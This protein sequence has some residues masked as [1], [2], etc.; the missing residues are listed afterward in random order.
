MSTL[1]EAYGRLFHGVTPS[2]I[3][4][5]RV[6]VSSAISPRSKVG[7]AAPQLDEMSRLIM[8]LVNDMVM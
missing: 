4:T 3:F 2:P 5:F 7:L 8:I 1:P 6:F